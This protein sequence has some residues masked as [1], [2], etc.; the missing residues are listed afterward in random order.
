MTRDRRVVVMVAAVAVIVGMTVTVA[1]AMTLGVRVR[2]ALIVFM[3]ML[4]RVFAMR[5]TGF[6]L[7]GRAVG[8]WGCG[9]QGSRGKSVAGSATC[10]SMS[11]SM[12]LMCRSAAR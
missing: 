9:H 5:V 10:S 3:S 12:P 6:A 2:R 4:M 11:A 7:L 8:N 1:M